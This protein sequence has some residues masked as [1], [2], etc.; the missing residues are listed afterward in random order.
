MNATVKTEE[1]NICGADWRDH[2]NG[3][4][5][6]ATTVTIHHP[7]FDEVVLPTDPRF[8]EIKKQRGGKR[9]GAGRPVTGRKKRFLQA[10]DEEWALILKDADEVRGK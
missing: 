10:T 4:K 3:E 6:L 2:P 7:D 9:P 8:A 1:K 5:V